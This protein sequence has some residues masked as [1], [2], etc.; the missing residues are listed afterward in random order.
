MEI[1]NI[2]DFLK[3][4]AK[5]K[6][7]TRRLF[8]YI[9]K[10]K[11][12]WTFEEGKFTIGDLIRHLANIERR[13]YA[14]NAQFKPSRYDGC[15]NNYAKGWDAVTQYYDQMQKESFDIFSKLT[16]EDLQKKTTTPGNVQITLW[17]WLRAMVE[18]E[19]H[20]RG[21]LYLYLSILGIKTPPMYGLTS[22]EVASRSATD[23]SSSFDQLA[24]ADEILVYLDG[25]NESIV[26][27]K[28]TDTKS[29]K[30][31]PTN[32][33]LFFDKNTNE[34]DLLVLMSMKKN[35]EIEELE[36]TQGKLVFDQQTGRFSDFFGKK[37]NFDYK[38]SNELST[39]LKKSIQT[40][41]AKK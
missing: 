18:H 5:V 16:T 7:R 6:K 36:F 23:A 38:K 30:E 31:S 39:E 40:F 14:E 4:Y 8:D 21:Q 10:E 25:K 41:L 35:G 34:F 29:G 1:T 13:M 15:G 20:H 27:I 9:P 28:K 12:E 32:H 11:I 17:K 37:I 26:A 2:D 19:V 3:Y 24:F 22:E 33:W